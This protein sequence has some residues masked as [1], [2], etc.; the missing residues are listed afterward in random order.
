MKKSNRVDSP[1]RKP[2]CLR[3]G[4]TVFCVLGAII[5]LAMGIT[6]KALT[7]EDIRP[8]LFGMAALML[9]FVWLM[10]RPRKQVAPPNDRC[11]PIEGKQITVAHRPAMLLN[12]RAVD[13]LTHQPL[14]KK[15]LQILR[16]TAL[17]NMEHHQR[18]LQDCLSLTTSTKQPN[19]FFPRYDLLI[20]T[21]EELTFYHTLFRVPHD[22]PADALQKALNSRTAMT[23]DFIQRSHSDM[24][25]KAA[26]LKTDKGRFGRCEK[27]Y[28]SMQPFLQ[29]LPT[30]AADLLEQYRQQDGMSKM[31]IPKAVQ[32]VT[33]ITPNEEFPFSIPQSVLSLLWIKGGA[34]CNCTASEA[35]EPSAIDLSLPLDLSPNQADL[36]E[37][38]GYYPSYERLT[39]KQRTVYLH[40]L[41]DISAPVPIGYVFIFYYGLERFLLTEKYEAALNM[42]VLLRKHHNN[43]SL[44]AYSADAMLVGC[45]L[46][47]RPDLI[48]TIDLDKSSS[49]LY[50]YIKGYLS[51]GLSARDLMDTCRRWNFTN[52]RYIKNEPQKFEDQLNQLLFQ[53]FNTHILPLSHSDYLHAERN[54]PIVLANPSLPHDARFSAAKD[55]TSNTR[56]AQIVLALLQSAHDRVKRMLAD[57]RKKQK[58]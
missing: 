44:F 7:E 14:S 49:E 3:Y 8:L 20:E 16:Q 30:E 34:L 19:I 2:G 42:M 58:Q 35:N 31:P 43:G 27:Y 5:Y 22:D 18:V 32:A 56:I 47:N 55:I 51:H 53:Q 29:E 6:G 21:L 50:L 24:V 15:E 37:D 17:W 45:L 26:A 11:S 25:Q 9:F 4:A 13:P 23:Y 46:H 12:G 38:I 33:D 36:T 54:F 48:S 28:Q 10:W 41:Q 52:T 1:Q 40:W 39:P 57:E